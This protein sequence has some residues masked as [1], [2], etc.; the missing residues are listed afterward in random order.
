MRTGACAANRWREHLGRHA[1]R[2]PGRDV[3]GRDQARRWRS[4]SPAATVPRRSKTVT[5]W[6]SAASSYAVVTPIT[7]APITATCMLSAGGATARRRRRA[8]AASMA[9]AASSTASSRPAP[10]Q[11]IRPT[12][13][14]PAPWHGRLRAQPS[15]K[16]TMLGLRSSRP[17]AAKN[18]SSSA[19]QRRERRGDDRHGRR[20]QGVARRRARAPCAG[21][22][23]AG[24]RSGRCSRPRS[25]PRRGGCGAPRAG[26]TRPRGRRASGDGRPSSRRR[27]SRRRR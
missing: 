20:E 18:A 15:R 3:A 13:S 1:G 14:S 21:S 2:R 27:R 19:T 11:T 24:R 9:S 26:R 6:P 10:C 23:R 12:G 7:P 4:C 22:R 17:L 5:S 16:L 25:S 8:S